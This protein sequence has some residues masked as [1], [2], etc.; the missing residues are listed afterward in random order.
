MSEK[1]DLFIKT[2]NFNDHHETWRHQK[3]HVNLVTILV[4]LKDLT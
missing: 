4:F 3:S 1:C 2:L